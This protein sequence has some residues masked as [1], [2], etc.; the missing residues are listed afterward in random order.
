[1]VGKDFG[2]V[3]LVHQ[4]TLLLASSTVGHDRL[5]A[6]VG[7]ARRVI[8]QGFGS[9][10]ARPL[11]FAGSTSCEGTKRLFRCREV[12]AVE[13]IGS[14][15]FVKGVE[16]CASCFDFGFADL[17]ELAR[18]DIAGQQHEER[19]ESGCFEG[20]LPQRLPRGEHGDGD[21]FSGACNGAASAI[22]GAGGL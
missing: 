21:Q 2:Q 9:G 11:A 4:F 20:G 14:E 3:H 5:A 1:M 10:R 6:G 18:G 7:V 19:G 22:E 15:S 13:A 17:V 12:A 16:L 8:R